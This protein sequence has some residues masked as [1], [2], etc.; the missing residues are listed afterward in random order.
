MGLIEIN[1]RTVYLRDR[2]G[3]LSAAAGL[4]IRSAAV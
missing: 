3:L 4:T 1:R 2:D